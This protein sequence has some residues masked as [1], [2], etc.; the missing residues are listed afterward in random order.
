MDI[1]AERIT[2]SLLFGRFSYLH[3]GSGESIDT[4][5]LPRNVVAFIT[6]A[7][8]LIGLVLVLAAYVVRPPHPGGVAEDSVRERLA[9]PFEELY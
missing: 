2:S 9:T 4:Q 8:A 6:L 3:L 7:P 1:V 5:S